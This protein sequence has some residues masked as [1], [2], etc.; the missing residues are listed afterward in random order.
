M[1]VFTESSAILFFDSSN[2]DLGNFFISFI[3]IPKVGR[4]ISFIPSQILLPL[5]RDQY[6]ISRYDSPQ[7]CQG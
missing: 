7:I 5:K 3:R 4:R 1:F 6:D 2:Y